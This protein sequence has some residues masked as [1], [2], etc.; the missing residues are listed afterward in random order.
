M[1]KILAEKKPRQVPDDKKKALIEIVRS[2]ARKYGMEK[3]PIEGILSE[4][5]RIS[6]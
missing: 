4:S 5:E 2:R 1:E 6:K 3:L